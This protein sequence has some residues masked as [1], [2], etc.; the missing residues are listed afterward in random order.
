MASSS[1]VISKP[2]VWLGSSIDVS[3]ARA[4]SLG[5]KSFLIGDLVKLLMA[6]LLLPE[7]WRAVD[8]FAN[9]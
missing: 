9:R 6:A 4:V 8:K 3:L 1:L 7:A 2:T 5:M